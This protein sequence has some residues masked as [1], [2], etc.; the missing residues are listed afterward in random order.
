[1]TDRPN[2]Q[3]RAPQPRVLVVD[4]AVTVRAYTRQ[5]LESDGFRVDEA[6]NGIDGLEHALSSTPD[7][8]IVDIN[9]QKMDGYTMLRRLRQ[10]HTLRDVPAIMISTESKDSDR[11]KALLAG[12]NWYFVKPVRPADLTAAARLLTGREARS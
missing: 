11:E 5:V 6:V 12:A 2:P 10:E 4:D 7:L 3:P 1:M 8:L 9:M